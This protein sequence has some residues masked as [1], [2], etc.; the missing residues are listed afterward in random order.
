MPGFLLHQGA[1]VQCLHQ[2][3]A[4]PAAPNPR[5]KVNGQAIVMQTVPYTIAG[6][7]LNISGAPSP[8]MTAQWTKASLRITSGG[9]PVLL[10]DSQ[11]TC[12]PNGT[13]L[14]VALT[15]LRVKGG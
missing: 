4:Q 6:C 10:Q 9:I 5:V 14:I 1:T 3:Q 7:P 13:G 11:A 12:M 8:C 2:G 15:Q